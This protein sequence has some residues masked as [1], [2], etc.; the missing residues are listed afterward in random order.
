MHIEYKPVYIP[1][2]HCMSY[3]FQVIITLILQ[4]ILFVHGAYCIMSTICGNFGF[5]LGKFGSENFQLHGVFT[6]AIRHLS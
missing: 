3:I 6:L 5:N 1:V 2:I 4:S